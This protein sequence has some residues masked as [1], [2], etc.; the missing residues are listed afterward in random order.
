M[1]VLTVVGTR[2]EFIQTAPVSKALRR[3]H[4]ETLV[5]T[6]QH[7]DYDMSDVFFTELELPKPEYNLGVGSGSHAQQTGQMMIQLEKVIQDEKPDWILVYGDTNSTVAG[8]LTAAKLNIP[9]AHIE[10]GLRSFDRTMP[11]EINRIITDHISDILFTPTEAARENL[12]R[13]GIIEGVHMVG[14][15]RVDI[16]T[17]LSARAGE[18][19]EQLRAK[20]NLTPDD[21]FA[22]ATIHRAS[23]TDTETRLRAIIETMSTMSLPVVLPVHPRLRKML[24]TFDLTFGENVRTIP[25]AS[26][27]D[28]I[29]LLHGCEIVITDSGGLQKEAYILRR[30][31]VTVR[32]STEWVET[33]QAGWNRLCK[34]DPASFQA[35]VDAARQPP[36]AGHPDFYGTPGVGARICDE[37][38]KAL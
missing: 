25:P 16:L 8:S 2:P 36:P 15:V 7:Y 23:N 6:G 30:P 24:D 34:P 1:K 26:F 4:T 18:R 13:E 9:V 27:L 28:M 37:L 20:I 29:A 17:Q 3:Q 14:D 11:E 35:A 19:L 21:A 10:A 33:V 22:L 5:H 12:A 31:T 32:D 38:A